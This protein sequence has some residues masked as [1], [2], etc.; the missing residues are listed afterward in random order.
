MLAVGAV[1]L[2]HQP[3][4]LACLEVGAD[5]ACMVERQGETRVRAACRQ[6]DHVELRVHG[7]NRAEEPEHLVDE[8]AAEITQEAAGRARVERRRFVEVHAGVDATEPAEAASVEL[9]AQRTDV[10]VPAAV[11]KDGE[12]DPPLRGSACEIARGIG[13]GGEGLVGDDCKPALIASSTKSRRDSGGV[14]I[15]TASMPP[16]AI[17][18]ARLGKTGRPGKSAVTRAAV[19]GA[20]ATTPASSIPCA[21][22]MKGAWKRRPPA[23]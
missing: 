10:G 11:V 5:A 23:P 14:V 12:D 22:A 8:V 19:A 3:V 13:G 21:A 20:R 17:I 15:V 18:A 7:S 6:V 16:A 2:C 4:D 1:F 9:A